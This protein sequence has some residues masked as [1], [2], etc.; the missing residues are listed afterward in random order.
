MSGNASGLSVMDVQL[1]PQI[2]LLSRLQYIIN[3]G[4]QFCVLNGGPGVGK[5]FVANLLIEQINHTFLVNIKCQK[6]F[7][8]DDFQ[9]ELIC[10]LATDDLSELNQPLELALSYASQ[11]YKTPIL[12]LIDN[13]DYMSQ[14]MVNSLLGSFNE[15]IRGHSNYQLNI[16]LVGDLKRGKPISEDI[17]ISD[18]GQISEYTLGYLSASEAKPFL[19]AIHPDWST[20][21][22]DD[23]LA[24]LEPQK[25][26]PKNLIYND[27]EL[28]VKPRPSF[29]MPLL[30]VLILM[31]LVVF[32]WINHNDKETTRVIDARSELPSQTFSLPK[33]QP[34]M[35]Q[36][37][38]LVTEVEV[39]IDQPVSIPLPV[40]IVEKTPAEEKL[41]LDQTVDDEVANAIIETHN[42]YVFDEE[43]LLKVTSSNVSLMLGGYSKR[44]VLDWIVLRLNNQPNVYIYQTIRNDKEWFVLLYG[45]F[46]DR[47]QAQSVLRN[48]P[49]DLRS[50]SPWI[51][52][53][54]AI[55]TEILQRQL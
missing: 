8:S 27:T 49:A 47:A 29:L 11:Y 34:Q 46:A 2:K 17:S 15:F 13:A 10:Q 24:C 37:P 41:T 7:K 9:R 42:N 35:I 3:T 30:V 1:D 18:S 12:I 4:S 55:Q 36:E 33:Q 40:G 31:I 26:S 53:F 38:E 22:L 19:S 52:S 45:S 50:F 5:S 14:S 48:I 43:Y 21:Q 39:N 16:L 51:K 6:N 28:T 20:R 54:K 25:I 32:L 23:Y 44:A